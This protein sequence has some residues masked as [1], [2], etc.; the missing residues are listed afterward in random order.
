M[1]NIN[2]YIQ[3]EKLGEGTYATVHKVSKCAIQS[4]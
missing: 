4:C 1:S 2:T 3:L